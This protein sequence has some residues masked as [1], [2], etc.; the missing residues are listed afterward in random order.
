MEQIIELVSQGVLRPFCN[1][2]DAKEAKT[3]LVVLDGLSNILQVCE[4]NNAYCTTSQYFLTDLRLSA[5]NYSYQSF[6]RFMHV[7]LILMDST[8]SFITLAFLLYRY[9]QIYT[10]CVLEVT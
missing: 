10:R 6:N 1:M 8:I 9:L 4:N 2:L 3:V 5:T 7:F